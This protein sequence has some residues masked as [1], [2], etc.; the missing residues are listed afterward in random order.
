MKIASFSLTLTLSR[1]EREK[2]LPD[3]VKFAS[4]RAESVFGFAMK[5]QRDLA[6]KLGAFLNLCEVEG[7]GEG[8]QNNQP[9]R[10]EKSK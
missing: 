2:M 7:W 6:K 8:E 5:R 9:S 3:F 10:A 4:Q 1:W